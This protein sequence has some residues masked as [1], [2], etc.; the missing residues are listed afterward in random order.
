[1]TVNP[2]NLKIMKGM[3]DAT[4]AERQTRT[5]MDTL[6]ITPAVLAHWKKPPFQR[7]LLVNSRVREVVETIK[8]SG[9]IIPGILTIGKIGEDTYLVDGQ[10]RIEAF[11]MAGV[12]EGYADV[13]IHW[14]ESVAEMAQ[15][16]EEL[17]SA[18]VT[19][20]ADDLL[21]ARESYMPP[22]QELRQLCPFIGYT[23]VRRHTGSPLI[24]MSAVLRCW[25]GSESEVPG[26]G[27]GKSARSAA[28]RLTMD[29][30]KALAAFLEMPLAAWGRD[31]EFFRL[32]GNLT[33]CLS[34][35]LYRRT[36]IQ[37][38]SPN[39]TRLT[40]EQFRRGL[41][42]LSA[43]ERFLEYLE[44]R[45]L[46]DSSRAPTYNRIKVIF[47]ARLEGEFGKGKTGATKVR[48]PT[49]SWAHG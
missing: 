6:A 18:L 9:G 46:N 4:R 8:D 41:Q 5:K 43:D 28:E 2:L 12:R 7:T 31:A 34:M 14:F 45:S 36:V 40:R 39:T 33:L 26:A 24:S 13:R 38:Y 49:P 32:W 25:F 20:K 37:L 35:W 10:H 17:N 42:G 30:T 16:F 48:L 47:A 3:G 1:M 22:L 19:W 27:G 15:E 44:G 29:E 23:M 21:R 11:K